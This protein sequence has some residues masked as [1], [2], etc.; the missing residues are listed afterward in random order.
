MKR[1]GCDVLFEVIAGLASLA[2]GES[3]TSSACV[4]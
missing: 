4:G 2:H 1:L 3:A